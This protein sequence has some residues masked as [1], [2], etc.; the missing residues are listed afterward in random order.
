MTNIKIVDDAAAELVNAVICARLTSPL[1]MA[2]NVI[3]LCSKCGE[4]IQHRPLAPKAPP[5]ICL[6]CARSL[7]DDSN[8]VVTVTTQTIM[9]EVATHLNKKRGH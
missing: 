7:T 2:D 1:L 9:N 3:A 4:A 8:D 5:K 6:Q